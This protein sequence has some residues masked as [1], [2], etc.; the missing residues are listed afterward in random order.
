MKPVCDNPDCQN[1]VNMKSEKTEIPRL[2]STITDTAIEN[3]LDENIETSHIHQY[4]SMVIFLEYLEG[5]DLSD[6]VIDEYGKQ[7]HVF[8]LPMKAIDLVGLRDRKIKQI[9]YKATDEQRVWYKITIVPQEKG[10]K[11]KILK[12][13]N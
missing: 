9:T 2:M 12:M 3:I 11:S 10:V 13:F 4:G 8:L 7:G 1:I 5:L 6:Q